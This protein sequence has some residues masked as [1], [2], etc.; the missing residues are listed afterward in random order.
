MN[1]RG[2]SKATL[3]L[4][5]ACKKIIELVQPI[6]IRGMCY[7]LFVANLIESMATKNTKKISRLLT[8]A[9][10]DGLIPWEW[11]VDESRQIEREPHWTNLEDYGE[12]VALSYRR[13]FWAHQRYRVI[14]MSEKATVAGILRPVLDQ[15]GVEFFPVH[16]FNSATK[17]H[18]LA[19]EI[20]KDKRITVILYVGDHDP[21]GMFMSVVDL[22]RRLLSYGAPSGRL[23][24]D[25][26]I[27]EAYVVRRVALTTEDCLA[28]DLPSFPAKKSD[29]RYRW[30]VS[31]YGRN[32]WELDAMNPNI[33][34]DRVRQEIEK[35]IQPV[36]WERHKKI[37]AAQRE[38]THKIARAI[39]EA[40]AN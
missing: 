4:L 22:P 34:R 9:R 23:G 29:T 5:Q 17:M 39:A 7:R 6:G 40:G 37:E 12:A 35:Y 15:Y 18:D 24:Q 8:L 25:F 33:L 16:G 38:T 27:H 1:H 2:R 32:A 14:V 21:S 31:N 36:D 13:D 20:A 26:E 28:G 11:I 30:Y 3:D 10:E 19:R